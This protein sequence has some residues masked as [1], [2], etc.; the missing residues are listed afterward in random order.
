[1]SQHQPLEPG[2]ALEAVRVVEAAALSASRWTG[3]GNEK[4]AD[5]AAVDTMRE[6]LASL[7]MRGRV[8][9][10]EGERDDAPMLFIGEELGI[11]NAPSVD[12]AVDP[13]EGTTLCAN[14]A[15][16]ALTVLAM[17]S[18]GGLLHAPDVYMEKIAAGPGLPEDLLSINHAAHENLTRLADAKSC[19]PAELTVVILD[20]PRH[21]SLIRDYRDAGARVQ[22]IPDGDISAVIAAASPESGVDLYVGTGGAPEGILAAAALRCIGGQMQGRLTFSNEEQRQRAMQMGIEEPD[23]VLRCDDMASGEI[24]FAATGV[25]DGQLLHGVTTRQGELMTQ[26]LLMSSWSGTRRTITTRH[27]L[28][29]HLAQLA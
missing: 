11:S 23:A 5:R 27:D 1:M 22:L 29:S 2:L 9:I 12:I 25:T 21:E 10:G 6:L 13:L 19:A 16:G 18:H 20:R 8:V 15:P 14:G 28:L 24:L 3:L 4:A 7:E 26:S 17:A